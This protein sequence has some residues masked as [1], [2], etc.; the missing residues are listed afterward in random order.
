MKRYNTIFTFILGILI[1]SVYNQTS[2]THER[3]MHTNVK[4]EPASFELLE[5]FHGH[6]GPYV[7]IGTFMGEHA[8]THYDFPQFFG[9]SVEAECPAAP[10]HSCLIDGLQIG[11]GATMGKRNIT[12]KDAPKIK[13][14]IKNDKTGESAIYTLKQ[15]TIALLK[16][17]ADKNIEVEERGKKTYAMS[18]EELFD[19]KY[20]KA[21]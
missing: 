3:V 19:V 1:L 2:Q 9:V 10:P 12:I 8:V 15:S 4:F 11:T 14:T 7:V 21:K 16:E 17:W 13:I 18:G 20:Q 5:R 6:V